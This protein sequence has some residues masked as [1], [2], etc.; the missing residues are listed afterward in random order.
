MDIER[1]IAARYSASQRAENIGF[2]T[3]RWPLR[4]YSLPHSSTYHQ[5]VKRSGFV[6]NASCTIPG[7]PKLNDKNGQGPIDIE[8]KFVSGRLEIKLRPSMLKRNIVFLENTILTRKDMD[9]QT[10]DDSVHGKE[11]DICN[12]TPADTKFHQ[13]RKLDN[14]EN[15]TDSN[16]DPASKSTPINH[17][18]SILTKTICN[19]NDDFRTES[20]SNKCLEENVQPQK[21]VYEYYETADLTPGNT[22]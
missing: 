14:V 12:S 11:D 3:K 1:N 7:I 9:G 10:N 6:Q 5:F 21:P 8:N 4:R 16:I 22:K 2:S 20:N 15:K 18:K 17:M 13:L 19:T